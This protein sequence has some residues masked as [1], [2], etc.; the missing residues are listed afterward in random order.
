MDRYSSLLKKRGIKENKISEIVN[1]AKKGNKEYK[2]KLFRYIYPKLYRFI[3]YRTNNKTEAEDLT[4]D[5]IL[6]I[7]KSLPRQ[8]GNFNSWIYKIARN[9]LIDFY[10]RQSVRKSKMS[11]DEVPGEIPDES[12]DFT[13]HILNEA[14]LKKA[15]KLLTGRQKEVIILKFIEGYKNKE[16]AKIIGTSEGAVKLLQFR[17]LKQMREYFEERKYEKEN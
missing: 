4:G 1:F 9:T 16:I 7:A 2:E 11:V 13:E 8:K 5:V 6:K 3:Y 14:S 10:R 15:M 12:K 17:A